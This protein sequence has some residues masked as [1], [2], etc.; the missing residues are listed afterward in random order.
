MKS[1]KSILLLGILLLSVSMGFVLVPHERTVK[2]I[3]DG[4]K[5][6]QSG[7]SK[8]LTIS[9]VHLNLNA[10][11]VNYGCDT[12]TDIWNRAQ[13]KLDDL[14]VS[15]KPD[16]VLYL[17][18]LPV[19]SSQT[20]PCTNG[21]NYIHEGISTV[22]EGL[23][24]IAENRKVPLLYLPGNNDSFGGDYNSFTDSIA[25]KAKSPYTMD[26]GGTKEWPMINTGKQA[27]FIDGQREFGFFSAYPLGKPRRGQKGL[28]TIMLNTVIFCCPTSM[29][30]PYVVDDNVSQQDA[31]IIQLN[32][33]KQQLEAASTANESV[34]IAMHIPP[35]KGNWSG[36]DNWNANQLYIDS[37]GNHSSFLTEFV[38][39]VKQ[40]QNNIVGILTSHTHTDG[41]KRIIDGNDVIE[42][43]ISTPGVSVNHSNNP[44]MKIFEYNSSNH[45]LLD[46]TTYYTTPQ[47]QTWG[48]KKYTF[49]NNYGC[50]AGETMLDCISRLTNQD[51]QGTQADI[52][53]LIEQ[54]LYV[55][56]P[57]GSIYKTPSALDIVVK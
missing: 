11:Q 50:S 52:V 1:K 27:T 37:Q 40:Y 12:G 54:I 38:N 17:G 24:K 53:N 4:I 3:E 29:W 9:D 51:P 20:Y 14:I 55:R 10:D 16:F 2:T 15:E 19:H 46:F 6:V 23:R 57:Q 7:N 34:L 43:T 36:S 42:L 35:G 28:R 13:Q 8:F 22:L 39:Q 49:S 18:D 48:D 44:G 33:L 21:D 25:G 30:T 45:E 31:G 41:L 26:V 32:W 5:V 56:S 47:A